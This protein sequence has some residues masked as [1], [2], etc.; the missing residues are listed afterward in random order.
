M[1]KTQ[2]MNMDGGREYK[3]DKTQN[4]FKVKSVQDDTFLV[5]LN[6]TNVNQVQDTPQGNTKSSWIDLPKL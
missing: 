6:S 1:S 4:M 3:M 5:H 2:I